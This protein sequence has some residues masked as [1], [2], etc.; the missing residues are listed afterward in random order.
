MMNDA[1][2]EPIKPEDAAKELEQQHAAAE[3]ISEPLTPEPEEAATEFAVESVTPEEAAKE[4]QQQFG[5]EPEALN[6]ED[7]A[8]ELERRFHEKRVVPLYTGVAIAGINLGVL[9]LAA[10]PVALN[11]RLHEDGA[12]PFVVVPFALSGLVCGW[13]ARRRYLGLAAISL[14]LCAF[15][16]LYYAPELLHL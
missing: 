12:L 9:A 16:A 14:N 5:I 15:A 1:D 3:P 4:L 8:L 13:I 11:F 7:A 10:I 6:P 2:P